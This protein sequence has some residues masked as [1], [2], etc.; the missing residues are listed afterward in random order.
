LREAFTTT[1]SRSPALAII[2]SSKMPPPAS[3]NSPY[4]CRP[5]GSPTMSAGTSRSSATAAPAPDR[6]TWPM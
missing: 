2:R 3:V 5:T 4:R 6:V 1:A